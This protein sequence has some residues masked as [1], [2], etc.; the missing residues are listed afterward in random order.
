M[1]SILKSLLLVGAITISGC[2]ILEIPASEYIIDPVCGMKVD[3]AEAYTW[4]HKDDKYYFDNYNCK[5]SFR[6]N[7]E[8]FIN[9]KCIISNDT[10]IKK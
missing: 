3:K 7:P 8:K 1:K 2:S 10:L 4:K 9:N 5:Q 6:M